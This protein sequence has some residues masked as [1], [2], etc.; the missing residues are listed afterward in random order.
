MQWARLRKT[1]IKIKDLAQFV[2]KFVDGGFWERWLVF[3]KIAA[4]KSRQI[5]NK[6]Q[7]QE[8]LIHKHNKIYV[9]GL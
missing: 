6:P 1:W 2:Q 9:R 7:T 5:S 8:E 4:A 3:K